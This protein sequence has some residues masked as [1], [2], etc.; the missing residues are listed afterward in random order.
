MNRRPA[1]FDA[2]LAAWL[3]EGPTSGPEEV[4]SRTFARARSTRQDR[5]WLHRLTQPTRFQAMN[6]MLKVAAVAAFALAV[7]VTVLPRGPDIASAPAPSPS[8]SPSAIPLPPD[9]AQ[10]ALGTYSGPLIEGSAAR[11][12]LTIPEGWEKVYE[13][14]WSDLDGLNDYRKV[15]GPGEVAF[16][17]W[18]VA[19]V[20]ADPC[21]WKD[22]LA[23]P[24]V[25]PTA[26]DLATAFAQQ[27][28]RDGSGP[29]DVTFGGYPAKRIDLSVPA[30]FDV[31][32]CD[33]GVYREFLGPGESLTSLAD[34]DP[35]R[36]H[37]AGRTDVLYVIDIDGTPWLMR[38]WRHPESTAEDVAEMEAM[39]ASIHI[40]VLPPAPLHQGTLTAGRYT[41][42]PFRGEEWAPCGPSGT[43]CPEAEVDDDLRFT[44]TVPEGWAGEPFGSGIWLAAEH[45][46]GPAGAG[47]L[48]GRGG[49]MYSDPCVGE[50]PDVPVGPTVDDFVTALVTHPAL[51]VTEPVD[52][53]L[54]GYAGKYLALQAPADLSDCPDNFV[55]WDPTFY[56]QG[57]SNLQHIWVIDVDGVRVVIHGSEFPGTAPERSAE[58]AAVVDSIRI[59]EGPPA[60]GPAASL[61]APSL[62]SSGTEGVTNGWIAFSSQPHAGQ[63][64]ATNASRGG[65]IY[66]AH[67]SDDL[68]ML[69]SRGPGMDTNVCPAFSPDGTRLAYGERTDA[70]IAI[71]ILDLAPDGSIERTSRL[72]LDTTSTVAPC[73]RW[74]IDGTR[75]GSLEARN[76]VI[77]R[78]LDGSIVEARTGDPTFADFANGPGPLDSP[79]G[80]LSVTMQD[81]EIIVHPADGSPERTIAGMYPYAIAGWSPDS[82]KLLLMRDVSG[83]DLQL[84]AVSIDEPFVV[85]VIADVIPVNG[86]RSWPERRDL[87]WQ[88]LF[89]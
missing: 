4:L 36:P 83:H 28:G 60:P 67:D 22:S 87:S 49:W 38:T 6:T 78:G 35:S 34:V 59:D 30:D 48:I 42:A 86:A 41:V 16:G 20:F 84:S 65:D 8:P 85:E 72:P 29:T 79:S 44:F 26:D 61:A 62:R 3:E 43:P 51:D 64:M 77:V 70:G 2:R 32:T 66:L 25:G 82:T 52:V 50:D 55:A 33:E 75:I 46:S 13:I 80:E 17:W 37:M 9:P 47:F 45:N 19:N 18:Q 40:D 11:W 24:P 54:G 39:L 76:I 71:V 27:V 89:E 56:A 63:V 31:T 10:V 74:S 5:V 15:G 21:H 68:R 53:M 57:P 73:P 58:L 12:T 81:G 69:V 23:D 1:D 14:L 7:G 88:T